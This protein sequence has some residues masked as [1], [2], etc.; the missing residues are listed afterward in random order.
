MERKCAFPKGRGAGNK[1]DIHIIGKALYF[2]IATLTFPPQDA[3]LNVGRQSNYE[4][5]GGREGTQHRTAYQVVTVIKAGHFH[6]APRRQ[7]MA[8][9]YH[10]GAVKKYNSS[11]RKSLGICS[12]LLNNCCPRERA[13]EGDT[14]KL[15]SGCLLSVHA[16][17]HH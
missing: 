13:Q 1:V 4:A 9:S 17:Q 8:L 5:E 12:I 3:F 6:A 14:S 2:H 10:V 7:R 11:N 16:A 15:T